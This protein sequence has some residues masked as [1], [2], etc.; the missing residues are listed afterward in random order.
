VL[1]PASLLVRYAFTAQLAGESERAHC[2]GLLLPEELARAERFRFDDDR[3]AFV[4]AHALV[5]ATL[6][7]LLERPVG[8]LR[9]TLGE[10]GRP[11]LSQPHGAARL[12]FNLAHT[13]GLVAAAFALE[14]DVGI[15][16][17]HIDRRV[18]VAELAPRVFSDAERAGLDAQP[19]DRARRERFFELW[20]LKEAYVKAIGK[21]LAAPLREI[22]F[23]RAS[24]SE[25][26]RMSF[27]PGIADDAA[28][29][30]LGV[31]T[32]GDGHALAWAFACPEPTRVELVD[33]LVARASAPA[34]SP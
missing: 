2:R 19:S 28:R 11:E 21:G 9:F 26:P 12:R 31:R 14:H 16:V 29:F 5:N 18:R 23:E 24:A 33:H 32:L 22:T 1:E 10:H 3:D 8:S 30:S 6:S 27:G 13:H 7:E 15:D 34:P 4:L 20:T 17:E 25:P